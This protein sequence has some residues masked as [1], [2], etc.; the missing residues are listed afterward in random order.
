MKKFKTFL[1]I[2]FPVLS[3][4]QME[5]VDILDKDGTRET[6]TYYKDINNLLDIYAGTYVYTNGNEMFKIV[7]VKKTMQYNTLYYE[8][9]IIGA[10]QYVV[11]GVE[12][13]NTLPQLD[14]VYTNQRRHSIDGNSLINNNNRQWRCP[15]CNPNEKRLSANIADVSTDRHAKL[16][17]RRMTLNSQQVMKIKISRASGGTYDASV[18]PQPGFSL[19]VGEFTMIKQ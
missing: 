4:A 14:T 3:F 7:L 12:R 18:G 10:Y 19:P 9:L 15:E 1:L 2:L 6:N 16:F 5:V 8:D 13:V 11:N 17:L